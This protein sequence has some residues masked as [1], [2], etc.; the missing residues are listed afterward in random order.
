MKF[1]LPKACV[2]LALGPITALGQDT[3]SS[4]HAAAQPA[5]EIRLGENADGG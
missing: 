1:N 5:D 2:S 3:S 4:A